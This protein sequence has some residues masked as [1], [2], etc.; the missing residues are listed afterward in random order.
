MITLNNEQKV[1]VESTIITEIS[2]EQKGYDNQ[3]NILLDKINELEIAVKKLSLKLLF[4]LG[5]GWPKL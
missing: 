4:E 3:K 1:L 5:Y 2:N